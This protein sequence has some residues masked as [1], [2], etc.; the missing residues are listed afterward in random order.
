MAKAGE[1]D[2][3]KRKKN[4]VFLILKKHLQCL[5]AVV[6]LMGMQSYKSFASYSGKSDNLQNV[7]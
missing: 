7:D 6:G 5:C 4:I 1:E 3:L 2:E